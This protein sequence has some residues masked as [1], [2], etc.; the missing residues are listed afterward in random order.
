MRPLRRGSSGRFTC[1]PS[2]CITHEEDPTHCIDLL[3]EGL[4]DGLVFVAFKALDDHLLDQVTLETAAYLICAGFGDAELTCLMYI[5]VGLAARV[6]HQESFPWIVLAFVP[7]NQVLRA[8]PIQGPTLDRVNT[9]EYTNR[10]DTEMQTMVKLGEY[11]TPSSLCRQFSPSRQRD[12]ITQRD[13]EV[14]RPIEA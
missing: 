6:A 1:Q 12:S 2:D 7:R 9:Y 13:N 14:I 8:M 3:A 10:H 5:A 11:G 4:G